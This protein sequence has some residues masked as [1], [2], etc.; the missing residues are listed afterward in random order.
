[1]LQQTRKPYAESFGERLAKM[2][3]KPKLDV[4][5]CDHCNLR[6]A[7][8]LH[9]APLAEERF[10][11]LDEYSRDLE[12]LAAIEGIGGYF[13][14]IALMGGEPLLHPNI[15]EV[16][17][18]TRA[19][20]P[21]ERIVLCTNGLLLK[22]MGDDFWGA[23]AECGVDVAISPY[24]IKLD[25]E[26]LAELVRSRGV[27]A[28]FAGDIT[29]TAKGK[30]AFVHLALDPEG[31]CDPVRSFTSCPFGGRFMQLSRG[32]IWPCQ[33]TALHGAFARQFGYGMHDEPEDSLALDAIGSADDIENFRRR[34][35]PMCRYCDNGAL[36]VA[37]WE[38]SKFE[39]EE[40]LASVSA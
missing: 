1:M 19:H 27:R 22:R 12:R 8:C 34:S 20:L 40:W 21:N 4:Q 32:A 29:G 16:I 13:G 17:R 5:V 35:H 6:C 28:D 31:T 10:L 25:Y 38:Q 33:V 9:F 30:Q 24:P 39:A 7:G 23:L 11:D 3:A 36:T 14:S 18:T 26:E 2:A 37:P 15:V